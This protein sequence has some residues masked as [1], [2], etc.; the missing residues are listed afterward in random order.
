M[1]ETALTLREAWLGRPTAIGSAGLVVGG[2]CLI[3]ICAQ[4]SFSLPFSPVP[5]TGQTFAVLLVGFAV[6]L[7]GAALGATQAVASASMYVVVGGF[8]APVYAHQSHGWHVMTGA[9]GGYPAGFV[10]AAGL[11]GL[12]A[13]RGW[14]RRFASALGRC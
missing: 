9:T 12:L 6:L 5:L 7:V 14:D 2:A 1:S 4:V 13:E 11:K 10:V 3:A 8:G